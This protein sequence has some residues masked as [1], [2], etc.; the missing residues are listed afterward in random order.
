[1][2]FPAK[3]AIIY[4]IQNERMIF[5]EAILNFDLAIFEFFKDF[6]RMDWLTPIMKIITTLGD[7]GIFFFALGLV[8]LCF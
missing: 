4:K 1:M 6:V 5:L 3:K 2:K 8:M 7:E